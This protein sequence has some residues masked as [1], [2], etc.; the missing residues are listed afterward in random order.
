M[1]P[2]HGGLLAEA[3]AGRPITQTISRPFSRV[4]ERQ[5]GARRPLPPGPGVEHRLAGG[6]PGLILGWRQIGRQR[7]GRRAG[8]G[9]PWGGKGEGGVESRRE[10]GRAAC[11]LAN[12]GPVKFP[13]GGR[14]WTLPLNGVGRGACWF[15]PL[16]LG[17]GGTWG[18]ETVIKHSPLPTKHSRA[19]ATH[20]GDVLTVAPLHWSSAQSP[21]LRVVRGCCCCHFENHRCI[22][23]PV[24]LG[25]PRCR[26]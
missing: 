1:A 15:S 4:S 22:A 11:G 19:L 3:G 9:C 13:A 24:C 10:E 25:A 2:D 21:H 26:R 5:L 14:D 17:E 12:P 20:C 8:L 16:D 6:G 7:G 18:G 23:C